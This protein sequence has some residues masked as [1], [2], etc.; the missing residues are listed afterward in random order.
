MAAST[1]AAGQVLWEVILDTSKGTR[2]LNQFAN[3]ANRAIGNLDKNFKKLSI[4]DNMSRPLGRI[5]ASVNEFNKSLEASN[6]RVLAFGASVGA[7]YSVQRAMTELVKSTIE[8]EKSLK[9][10]NV[11]LNADKSG[12]KS[13]GVELFNIAKNTN[14]SFSAVA[15]AATELARQGLSAQETLKRTKDALVL[16][17]LTGMDS[18][19]AVDSITAALN[20]F[21]KQVIDSTMLVSKFAKV[22][23]AFAVSSKDLA[24]AIRRVGS[25]AQDA[26]VGI[27]ELIALVTSAQQTTARGGA[28]IG[29][30]LKTIFTRLQ[31][32]DTIQSLEDLGVAVKDIQNNVLPA[33]TVLENFAKTYD[34]LGAAQKAQAA[35]LVG[36]VFQ[37]N[38]LKSYLSDLSKENSF[39][40]SALKTSTSATDEAIVRSKELNETLSALV[41]RTFVNFK[42]LGSDIGG[43]AISKP[44]KSLLGSVNDLILEPINDKRAEETGASI[45]QGV[46][47]GIGQ[48]LSGPGVF[49]AFKGL[50]G[51]A[52]RLGADF[53]QAFK[54][55]SGIT[56][57]V[58]LQRSIEKNLVDY[59]SQE[60]NLTEQLIS[61]KITLVDVQKQYLA[62]VERSFAAQKNAALLA[63]GIIAGFKQSNIKLDTRTGELIKTKS[64]GLIP[65]IERAG[66]YA[67]GYLPGPVSSLHVKGVGNITYNKAEKVVDFGMS[68]PAIIPPLHSKAGTNYKKSFQAAHGFNPY[69]FVA[70]GLIPNFAASGAMPIFEQ[71]PPGMYGVRRLNDENKFESAYK[72]LTKAIESGSIKMSEVGKFSAE[73]S[74]EF[75]LTSKSAKSV[76]TKLGNIAKNFEQLRNAPSTSFAG[77][78]MGNLPFLTSGAQMIDLKGS[79]ALERRQSLVDLRQ[80]MASQQ[81]AK[82]EVEQKTKEFYDLQAKEAQVNKLISGSTGFGGLFL[83][84]RRLEKAQK[85]IASNPSLQNKL[86]GAQQAASALSQRQQ[87]VGLA[88]SF[89][90]PIILQTAGQFVPQENRIGKA[91]VEAAGDVVSFSALGAVFGKTPAFAAIGGLAGGIKIIDAITDKLPE[92][93]KRLEEVTNSTARLQESFQRFSSIQ[94]RLDDI[95]EGRVSSS[96]IEKGRLEAEQRNILSDTPDSV[97]KQLIEA[98]EKGDKEQVNKIIVDVMEVK[99][100]QLGVIQAGTSLAESGDR[101]GVR[102]ADFLSQG[103]G[104]SRRQFDEL[105][106]QGLSDSEAA[107][108]VQN[109]PGNTLGTITRAL[110]PLGSSGVT[111]LAGGELRLRPGKQEE[112]RAQFG[113][114]LDLRGGKEGKQSLSQFLQETPEARR[115]LGRILREGQRGEDIGGQFE[116]FFKNTFGF[117][118]ASTDLTEFRSFLESGPAK[119]LF[120]DID[121]GAFVEFVTKLNIAVD[122]LVKGTTEAGEKLSAKT[123]TNF[124]IEN[125]KALSALLINQAGQ[126]DIENFNRNFSIDSRLRDQ[127][128]GFNLNTKISEIGL[129]GRIGALTPTQVERQRGGLA[130][131]EIS[132]KAVLEELKAEGELLKRGG[133]IKEE[134]KTS[135]ISSFLKEATQQKRFDT[136]DTGQFTDFASNVL[137]RFDR[138]KIKTPKDVEGLASKLRDE[139]KR[140]DFVQANEATREALS[141]FYLQKANEL[142]SALNALEKTK[143]DIKSAEGKDIAVKSEE[144]KRIVQSLQ[145]QTRIEIGNLKQISDFTK[146]INALSLKTASDIGKLGLSN[147]KA[148]AGQSRNLDLNKLISDSKLSNAQGLISPSSFFGLRQSTGLQ[149]I[150][151]ARI[152]A[153][154]SAQR[155]FGESLFGI[156]NEASAGIF[157]AGKSLFGNA[158]T[159]Q[160]AGKF[161]QLAP[162]LQTQ[163]ESGQLKSAL[164]LIDSTISTVN[165]NEPGAEKYIVALEEARARVVELQRQEIN[166][167]IVRDKGILSAEESA[168]TQEEV[169]KKTI[170]LERDAAKKRLD[171]ALKG[172]SGAKI[173]QELDIN[174]AIKISENNGSFGLGGVKDAFV[175]RFIFGKEDMWTSIREGAV[176]TADTIKSSFK[177]AF[178]SFVDGTENASDAARKFGISIFENILSKTIDIGTDSLFGG[179]IGKL[180]SGNKKARGGFI[181]KFAGGGSVYGGSGTMDDVPA[182]LSAGEFVVNRNSASKYRGLLENMNSQ[183]AYSSLQNQFVYNG[184]RPT[185]GQAL[186]DPNLSAMALL[187]ENNP[188]NAIRLQREAGLYSYLREFNQFEG[189]KR[190]ALAQFRRTQRQRMTGAYMS[191]FMNIAGGAIGSA[192]KAKGGYSYEK[193]QMNQGYFPVTRAAGGSVSQYS[194]DSVPAILTPGEYVLNSNATS[195]YGQDYL[196]RLNRK[197]IDRNGG[198]AEYTTPVRGSM[199]AAQPVQTAAAPQQ[200]IENNVSINITTSSDGTTT[201]DTTQSSND[202]SIEPEKLKQLSLMI[203]EQTLRVI[204]EQQ[205]PGGR[206]YSA[207]TSPRY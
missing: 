16:V 64:D 77:S 184:T 18:A 115:E 108:R 100:A 206:L 114:L 175:S 51:I 131:A 207:N 2:Q 151:E 39:Y 168:R 61:K 149:N 130:I 200:I 139:A 36:G 105:K 157:G 129:Q 38:I 4:G 118:G 192:D 119:V 203:K 62:Q 143:I 181:K 87:N 58:D 5:S 82:L 21:N 165:K 57:Q 113:R 81:A 59:L 83:G 180:F 3:E 95:N 78:S 201:A 154:N 56:T 172:S 173:R 1:A 47:E 137:G 6:A 158:G 99:S 127:E 63:P 90:A 202:K 109:L 111:R 183:T 9:D 29:N 88:T 196:N 67:G 120:K 7:L 14:Q 93:R 186:V 33:Q 52:S 80:K 145:T 19:A 50:Q 174:D 32:T 54:T 68:Q 190:D 107:T 89:A 159:A 45:G 164:K 27:D 35:E 13:F 76:R 28:V 37:I 169:L 133:N 26:G 92:F 161:N 110:T 49:L 205:R 91:G 142:E 103:I 72:K 94:N 8:V 156:R 147:I 166:L 44:L 140:T 178:K 66:A 42:Q 152:A 155:G 182:L 171:I 40:A 112:A 144:V 195:Y 124:G 191:A 177:D 116:G 12:L 187:D 70:S 167:I 24:E 197:Q 96:T 15:K 20:S 138:L 34:R 74:K 71:N 86:P 17:Q 179:T 188:Q 162:Q 48:F 136:L 148:E 69:N 170:E 123:P 79:S 160:F 176:D 150:G 204:N 97:K 117:K 22:D 122:K 10:I 53:F 85:I 185:S 121:E 153:I 31:R 134:I 189:Q 84:N 46:L 65:A 60:K 141:A 98:F 25:S 135:G 146:Q 194:T 106:K 102:I 43:T 125:R 104:T 128:R 132:R 199:P 198:L 30:S 75:D 41:N 73:L 101:K 193:T 11:I 23:A 163:V 55:V 126:S